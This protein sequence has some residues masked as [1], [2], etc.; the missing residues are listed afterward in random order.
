VPRFRGQRFVVNNFKIDEPCPIRLFVID[1]I[2]RS[3]IAVRPRSAKFVAPEL[4]G[5]P[6]FVASCFDHLPGERALI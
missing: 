4:M 2:V 6:E 1:Y 5:A 3:C